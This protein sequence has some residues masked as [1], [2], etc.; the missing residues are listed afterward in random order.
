MDNGNL[1]SAK[2]SAWAGDVVKEDA[3][4]VSGAYTSEQPLKFGIGIYTGD[5][6]N[7]SQTN[8]QTV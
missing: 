7:F 3:D 1:R 4:T 2:I 6:L 8:H 5:S